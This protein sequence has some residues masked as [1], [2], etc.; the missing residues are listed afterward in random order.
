V[1]VFLEHEEPE[2]RRNPETG[3]VH[4]RSPRS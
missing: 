1:T 2:E 3:R 4:E